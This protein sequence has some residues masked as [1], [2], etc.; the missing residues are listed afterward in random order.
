MTQTPLRALAL[1]GAAA[2]VL[3][4]PAAAQ[5]AAANLEA[6]KARAQA[7]CAACHGAN[8]VSIADTIPNLA[9]QR[10]GY[11]ESQLRAFKA[12]TRKAASMNAIAAQLAPADITDVAA[13]FGSL[14][15]GNLAAKSEQLP[16][17]VKTRVTFP[18]GYRSTFRMYQ[19]VNRAD[20]NQVRYLYANPVAWQA[21]REGRPLPAGSVLLL[22]QWAAKLDAERK[23]VV[24]AGGFYTPD[25]LVA[26]AVMS[27]GAGWGNDFP[28]MLRNGD[29]NYAVFNPDSTLRAGVNQADCLACHKPLDKINYLFSNE[30]LLAAA[31]R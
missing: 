20:I 17:L 9:G 13:F 11:L 27:S 23:P 12:G 21:A 25:R 16:N 5:P 2:A 28:E 22:E 7:V 15:P 26:Y 24:G 29:W 31:K 4:A 19:T 10:V 8:G 30:P 18:E 3:A 6:G 14:A 1:F